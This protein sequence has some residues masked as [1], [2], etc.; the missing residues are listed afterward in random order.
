[1][2]DLVPV[3]RGALVADPRGGDVAE[4]GRSAELQ[5]LDRLSRVDNSHPD[6]QAL[7]AFADRAFA[8]VLATSDDPEGVAKLRNEWGDDA[9]GNFTIVVGFL[10]DNPR[11][12]GIAERFGMD[13]AN[14][15][16][17]SL[18]LEAAKSAGYYFAGHGRNETR[19]TPRM[20]D[21]A[22]TQYEDQL[23]EMRARTNEAQAR[24]ESG[25]ANRLYQEQLDFIARHEGDAPIVGGAGRTV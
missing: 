17:Y 18:A 12:E 2:N 6:P 5:E 25:R 24:G 8:E 10:K 9:A 1:M 19:S 7:S 20:N 13:L 14:P 4:Q 21:S 3:S 23:A 11:L 22:R 16:I 15:G